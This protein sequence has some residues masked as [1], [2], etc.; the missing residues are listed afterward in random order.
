MLYDFQSQ[1]SGSGEVPNNMSNL[2]QLFLAAVQNN[3]QNYRLIELTAAQTKK[4]DSTCSKLKAGLT[5]LGSQVIVSNELHE[6]VTQAIT[7]LN[8]ASNIGEF[9]YRYIGLNS[10]LSG[11]V[12]YRRAT[13]PL[14]SLMLGHLDIVAYQIFLETIRDLNNMSSTK[15]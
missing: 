15:T 14:A 6:V 12:S 10:L 8:Q 3:S 11:L 2:S 5:A 7:E 9:V 13:K 1:V 4:L